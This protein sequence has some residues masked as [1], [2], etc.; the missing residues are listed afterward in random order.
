MRKLTYTKYVSP[1]KGSKLME[2]ITENLYY[3]NFNKIKIYMED[4]M[5]KT[6]RNRN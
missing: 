2:Y 6:P 1:F 5:S 4:Y 3:F